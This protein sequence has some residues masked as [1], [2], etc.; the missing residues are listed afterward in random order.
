[1][2]RICHWVCHPTDP[3]ILHTHLI[4]AIRRHTTNGDM[5]IKLLI[6]NHFRCLRNPLPF[7]SHLCA[8]GARSKLES[9]EPNDSINDL[10]EQLVTALT[11]PTTPTTSRRGANRRNIQKLYEMGRSRVDVTPSHAFEV[12]GAGAA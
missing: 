4:D 8:L 12:G 9:H 6:L 1:M 5:I 10:P 2:Y 7:P 11:R 3:L